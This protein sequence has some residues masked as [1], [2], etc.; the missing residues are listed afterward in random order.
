M[1]SFAFIL[2]FLPIWNTEKVENQL[3]EALEQLNSRLS[4]QFELHSR[5]EFI[6]Q[7]CKIRIY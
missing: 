2:V 1:R 3:A 4:S 7:V 5:I 6:H